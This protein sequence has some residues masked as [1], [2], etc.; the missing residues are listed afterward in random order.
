MHGVRTQLNYY[1]SDSAGLII[2]TNGE[3]N[4]YPIE[5]EIESYI[6]LFNTTLTAITDIN[7]SN[8][9]EF[10]KIINVL[11]REKKETKNELLFYIYDDGTVEKTIII[12]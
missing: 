8:N 4:Y 2:L 11:G 12:E 1:P 10:I 9:R 3:G 5:L 6:P 7:I